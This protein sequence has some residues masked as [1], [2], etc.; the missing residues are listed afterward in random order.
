MVG[1]A[2]GGGVTLEKAPAE[3]NERIPEHFTDE[4]VNEV[5]PGDSV[6]VWEGRLPLGK[7]VD[8]FE[9]LPVFQYQLV[10]DG[11]DCF[12]KGPG[13]LIWIHDVFVAHADVAEAGHLMGHVHPFG[14]PHPSVD[15]L[16]T[17]FACSSGAELDLFEALGVV[18]GFCMCFLPSFLVAIVGRVA[19]LVVQLAFISEKLNQRVW[20]RLGSGPVLQAPPLDVVIDHGQHDFQ[21]L[22][23]VAV[24][25]LLGVKRIILQRL[26][27]DPHRLSKP[28]LVHGSPNIVHVIR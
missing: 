20:G 25:L 28:V 27:C 1:Q 22:R 19:K 16:F 17:F 4:N 12:G 7:A 15:R 21:K 9:E 18:S 23:N 8:D 13:L 10:D 26:K 24:N 11:P 14:S 3:Y 6:A 5:V 2:Q